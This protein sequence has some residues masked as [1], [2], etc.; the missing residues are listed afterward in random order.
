MNDKRSPSST[1]ASTYQKAWLY[2]RGQWSQIDDPVHP[3][4]LSFSSSGRS[5]LPPTLPLPHRQSIQ[6]PEEWGDWE[7][8]ESDQTRYGDWELDEQT[9]SAGGPFRK[10][11]Y[12]QQYGY[13]PHWCF[14]AKENGLAIDIYVKPL[15]SPAYRLEISQH[16]GATEV[17]YAQDLPDLLR[18]LPGLLPLTH[19]ENRTGQPQA[20][21]GTRQVND[22][23]L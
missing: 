3:R 14:S 2:H 6:R 15:T 20:R 21:R 7:A 22:R 4:Y 8:D 9:P 5:L 19:A 18:L 23:V 16:Q 12:L 11:Q 13:S 17:I 10:A 1:P